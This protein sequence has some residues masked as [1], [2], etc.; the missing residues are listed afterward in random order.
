MSKHLIEVFN[1]SKEYKVFSK[2]TSKFINTFFPRYKKN[3]TTISALNNINFTV[4]PGESV[5]I[6]GKNGSGKSTLLQ[7]LSGTLEQT[8]G[9]YVVN[10]NLFA[11]LELGTGFNYEYTAFDNIILNGLFYGKGKK[12]ILKKIPEIFEFAELEG[13]EK[14]PLKIQVGNVIQ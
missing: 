13:Y 2:E 3:L 1:L 4:S 5:G 8:C 11:L 14:F 9:N 12:E 6:I 7:I 10:K